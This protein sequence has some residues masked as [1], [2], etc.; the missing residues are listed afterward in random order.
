MGIF[1]RFKK[2]GEDSE[3][4]TGVFDPNQLKDFHPYDT[5]LAQTIQ[6][7][8]AEFHE[9]A[10]CALKPCDRDQFIALLGGIS[11][12]R[13]T[14]GI[15]GPDQSGPDYF[16]ALPRCASKE[17]EEECRAHLEKVFGITDKKSL[18]DFCMKEICCH[19]QYSDFRGFWEDQPPFDMAQLNKDA[20]AFFQVARD[21]SAQF[22]SIVGNK[23]YLAWDIGECIGHLRVGYACGILNRTELDQLA[24]HWILKAQIFEN[25]AD[26]AVS[27]ICGELYW[28]FRHGAK[29]PELNQGLELWTRL[30]RILLEDDTAWGSG[31]W[32]DASNR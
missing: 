14:P 21:F 26:F 6:A 2:Q 22:Y 3:G 28:D 16:T 7:L 29:L 5:G 24:E 10:M 25:W 9:K 30:V 8:A 31:L 4:K 12:L 20:L 18:L 15:P 11:A 27:L 19:S 1:D 13:K 17:A 23:G 32:Y